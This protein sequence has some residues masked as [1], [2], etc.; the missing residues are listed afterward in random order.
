[1][2]YAIIRTGGKQYRVK[3]GDRLRVEKLVAEVGQEVELGDVL[4]RGEGSDLSFDAGA[5]VKVKVVRHGRGPKIK[6]WKSKRRKGYEKRQGHRQ[7][8]TEILVLAI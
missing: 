1:M 6:I 3:Q 4:A 5:P 7:D 8:F 2:S